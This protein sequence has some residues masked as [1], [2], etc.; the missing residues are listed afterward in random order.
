[1]RIESVLYRMNSA[2]A[3]TFVHHACLDSISARLRKGETSTSITASRS[4]SVLENYKLPVG[5]K[6][7]THTGRRVVPQPGVHAYITGA[8][9]GDVHE[10]GWLPMNLYLVL[11]LSRRCVGAWVGRNVFEL[12]QRM[13]NLLPSGCCATFAIPTC[14]ISQSSRSRSQFRRCPSPS[15]HAVVLQWG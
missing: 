15:R 11:C 6:D 12:G 5:P 2:S 7:T 4:Y 3:K 9:A 10:Q 1:M 13:M 8:G 14:G